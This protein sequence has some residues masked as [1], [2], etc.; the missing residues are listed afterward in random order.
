M[1]LIRGFTQSRWMPS[2]GKCL[3]HIAPAATMFIIISVSKKHNTQLG[4]T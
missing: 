1:K 3:R 4:F 2:L